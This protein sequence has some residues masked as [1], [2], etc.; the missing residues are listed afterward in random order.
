MTDSQ[1]D[2][3]VR[4]SS[5]ATAGD[6]VEDPPLSC[7][8]VTVGALDREDTRGRADALGGQVVPLLNMGRLIGTNR[9][10]AKPRQAPIFRGAR[11]HNMR[12]LRD[13]R[14]RD[15]AVVGYGTAASGTMRLTALASPLTSPSRT[16]TGIGGVILK[17]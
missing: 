7:R 5:C 17:R 16:L 11:S 15:D 1:W 3:V 14:E 8:S 12:S 10:N 6:S 9:A 4:L 13:M 2:S